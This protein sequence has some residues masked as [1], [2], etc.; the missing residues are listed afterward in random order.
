MSPGLQAAL[1]RAAKHAMTPEE[2]R[3]QRLSFVMG[4]LPSE[5]KMTREQVAAFLDK[6]EGRAVA[7]FELT[8]DLKAAL[9]YFAGL[10]AMNPPPGV[11]LN[12]WLPAVTA[13]RAA[14]KASQVS[15]SS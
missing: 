15:A 3:E 5:N 10:D 4:M 6:H 9:A 7:N 8:R 14:I 2:R 13:A 11:P 1:D 12:E